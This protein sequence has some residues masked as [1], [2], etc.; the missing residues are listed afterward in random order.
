M[1]PITLIFIWPGTN[2][3]VPSGWVRETAIDDRYPF[4][5]S[6][7][8]VAGL[9]DGSATH[10][11][12]VT[13]G[14]HALTSSPGDYAVTAAAT[15]TKYACALSTHNHAVFTA[16]AGQYDSGYTSNNPR[17]V[18]VIFIKPA[19]GSQTG[20]PAG[21]WAFYGGASVPANWSMPEAAKDILIRSS[22]A[23]GDAVLTPIGS[24]D[25]HAHTSAHSHGNKSSSLSSSGTSVL[26]PT[27]I[28]KVAAVHT[29]AHTVSLGSFDPG[30][31][32]AA[33]EPGWQK[34][35]VIQNDSG[36]P[37]LPD[38]VRALFLG[39]MADIP[40]NWSLVTITNDYAF[41]KGASSTGETGN[42]GGQV[43]F[44]HVHAGV[45]HGSSDHDLTASLANVSCADAGTNSV[46]DAGHHHSWTV[47]A[48]TDTIGDPT[49]STVPYPPCI[50]VLLIEYAA[51]SGI[52]ITLDV[53]V[54]VSSAPD[55]IVTPGP[56][57]IMLGI[58]VAVSSAPDIEV[59]PGS[60]IVTL[61]AALAT[62]LAPN[63]SVHLPDV[64]EVSGER[65]IIVERED[66]MTT[67]PRED[68]E[69]VVPRDDRQ[70]IIPE[71]DRAPTVPHEDRTVKS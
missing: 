22:V 55:L 65:L 37:D 33:S 36:L 43:D 60:V 63:I 21:A 19:N 50:Y 44:S 13:R 29:H 7:E 38:Q 57:S 4:A 47:G 25:P 48:A 31:G 35:A 56:T 18:D 70:I 52:S 23:S 28:V 26:Y 49:Q 71:E 39:L 69:M 51:P 3:S 8:D 58:A 16:T 68:R 42:V 64:V 30:M 34:N 1:L 54:A 15:G 12:R 10:T 67:V 17:H 5:T 41:M 62:S 11:H 61:E 45:S 59:V 66:R 46:S 2:A 9:H 27:G 32:S 6:A 24:N 40:E 14:A 20:V 53:A